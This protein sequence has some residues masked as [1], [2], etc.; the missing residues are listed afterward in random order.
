MGRTSKS[1]RST[2]SRISRYVISIIVYITYIFVFALY[3]SYLLQGQFRFEGI[4]HDN[5]YERSK[6]EIIEYVSESLISELN[7][8]HTLLEKSRIAFDNTDLIDIHLSLYIDKIDLGIIYFAGTYSIFDQSSIN[9]IN[10][11]EGCFDQFIHAGC[12]DTID[13]LTIPV[14]SC[15]LTPGIRW[16]GGRIYCMGTGEMNDTFLDRKSVV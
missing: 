5:S 3:Y 4:S 7:S 12:L 2:P 6:S 16:G 14:G 1:T 9:T 15:V 11:Q 13:A 10:R 8:V